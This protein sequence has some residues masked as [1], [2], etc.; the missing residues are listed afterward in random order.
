MNLDL[1][2]QPPNARECSCGSRRSVARCRV[3]TGASSTR[4]A[5]SAPGGS[6]GTRPGLRRAQRLEAAGCDCTEVRGCR[7]RL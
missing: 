2:Q 5:L 3:Q 1:D 6:S 7:R 4:S